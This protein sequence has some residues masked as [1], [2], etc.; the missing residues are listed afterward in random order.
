MIFSKYVNIILVPWT[1]ILFLTRNHPF[2]RGFP[3]VV[4]VTVSKEDKVIAAKAKV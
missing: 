2:Y 3:T 1:K 4:E